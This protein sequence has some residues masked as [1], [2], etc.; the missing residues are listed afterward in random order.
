V[1]NKARREDTHEA[2]QHH[3]RGLVTVDGVLQGGIE[4]FAAGV[5]R[6]VDHGRRQAPGRGPV[7]PGRIG[8]VAE[9]GVDSGAVAARPVLAFG[10]L[11]DRSH[12]GA[13]AGYQDDDVFHGMLG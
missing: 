8:A 4:G 3:Q 13:G 12:V 5:R 11:D 7:Q 2:R 1:C 6:V 10:G 9:H